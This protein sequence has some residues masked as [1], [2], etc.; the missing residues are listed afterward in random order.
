[1]VKYVTL[2]GSEKSELV[3]EIRTKEEQEKR[4]LRGCKQINTHKIQTEYKRNSVVV[5]KQNVIKS[6][7]FNS[8]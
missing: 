7:T 5:N 8:M 1:M 3:G 2:F 6:F 4:Y